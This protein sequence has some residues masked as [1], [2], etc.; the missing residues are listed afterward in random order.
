MRSF[1]V[2][3]GKYMLMQFAADAFGIAGRSPSSFDPWITLCFIIIP[4]QPLGGL[5]L[6]VFGREK[7][8]RGDGLWGKVRGELGEY[9]G[10]GLGRKTVGKGGKG[11]G[12][13]GVIQYYGCSV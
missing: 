6:C 1:K 9:L 12:G 13:Y 5:G 11:F 2:K 3:N 8:Y 4:S 7:G 10:G